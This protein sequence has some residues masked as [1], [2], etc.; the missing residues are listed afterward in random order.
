MSDDVEPEIIPPRKRGHP[1]ANGVNAPDVTLL[2]PDSG[3]GA[4]TTR[5]PRSRRSKA[6][7]IAEMAD[8]I[9]GAHELMAAMLGMPFLSIGHDRALRLAMPAH[10][11]ATK[12][13]WDD[14]LGRW[15]EI[16]LIFAM[17]MIYGPLA[18]QVHM[19]ILR[20]KAAA[21]E[22]AGNTTTSPDATMSD[23]GTGYDPA[24]ELQDI[25]RDSDDDRQF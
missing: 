8:E 22:P 14:G 9:E 11:V 2:N 16:K 13:G 15:P 24:S 25:G 5:R 4:A 20:R 17:G 3:D 21:A 7:K 18:G 19:E 10:A 1:R 12:Y 6:D 23:L